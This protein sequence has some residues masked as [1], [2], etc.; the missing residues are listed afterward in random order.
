MITKVDILSFF[1]LWNIPVIFSFH[2]FSTNRGSCSHDVTYRLFGKLMNENKRAIEAWVNPYVSR[3]RKCRDQNGMSDGTSFTIHVLEKVK[4]KCMQR[5]VESVYKSS[6]CYMDACASICVSLSSSIFTCKQ[7][8]WW[9][10]KME[11]RYN[12]FFSWLAQSFNQPFK[13]I[14]H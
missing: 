13:R 3:L 1:S 2:C 12:I 11:N 10:I 9:M 7:R 5:K 4:R 6:G 8:K 14:P